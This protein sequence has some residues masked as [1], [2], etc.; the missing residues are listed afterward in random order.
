MQV[1]Y[2]LHWV[3][4]SVHTSVLVSQV[5]WGYKDLCAPTSF[6]SLKSEA[7]LQVGEVAEGPKCG[8]LNSTREG[9]ESNHGGGGVW[10]KEWPGWE[11]GQGGEVEHMIRYR[12]KGNRTEVLRTTRWCWPKW[13]SVCRKVK[14]DPYLSLTLHRAQVQVD[15]WPLYKTR[16]TES[17]RRESEKEP[18][19]CWHRG[20]FPKQKSN[21]SC[22][23]IKNW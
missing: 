11:R 19:I 22:S 10:G 17:N 1:F 4:A 9:K 13:Q 21:G 15:Q 16:Y 7:L 3:Q 20:E 5:I 12:G 14:I 18:Q 6:S 23:K 8:C 2:F